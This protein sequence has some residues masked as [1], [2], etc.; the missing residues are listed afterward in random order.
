MIEV[1]DSWYIIF[2]IAYKGTVLYGNK[3]SLRIPKWRGITGHWDVP[4]FLYDYNG[5]Y[6][7][8]NMFVSEEQTVSI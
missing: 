2:K 3:R 7:I 5:P 4:Q 1:I 6:S 8:K